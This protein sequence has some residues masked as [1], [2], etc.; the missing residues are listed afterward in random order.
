M[1]DL[2]M[3]GWNSIQKNHAQDVLGWPMQEQDTADIQPMDALLSLLTDVIV[4]ATYWFELR[5]DIL[6]DEMPNRCRHLT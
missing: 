6:R 3:G 4:C 2:V 5:E 1:I